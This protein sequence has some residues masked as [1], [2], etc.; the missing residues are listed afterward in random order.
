LSRDWFRKHSWSH[1]DQAEFFARLKR[2]RSTSR[3]QYLFIQALELS[4]ASQDYDKVAI[5]LFNTVLEEY[6]GSSMTVRALSRKGNRLERQG[7]IGE[8][9]ECYRLAVDEMRRKLSGQTWAWLDL[10]WLIARE[11]NEKLYDEA[12][13]LI[14]EFG[15]KAV[16]FPVV[17]FKI[18]A[19]RAFIFVGRGEKEMAAEAACLSLAA[20]GERVSGLARHPTI[21]LVKDLNTAVEARLH[22][23]AQ[24]LT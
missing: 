23:I 16:R 15:R 10:V 20:A 22:R 14:T 13:S 24:R 12:L 3:A 21:G 9:I 17:E 2:A 8:A 1:E 7:R 19:S 5:S 11:S 6:P 18:E 4:E